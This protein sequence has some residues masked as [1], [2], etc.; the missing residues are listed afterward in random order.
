M[1]KFVIKPFTVDAIRVVDAIYLAAKDWKSLPPWLSEPYEKG[2]VVFATKSV[3]L[4]SPET[5]KTEAKIDD[6]IVKGVK[7]NLYG[8]TPELFDETYQEVGE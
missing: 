8:C 5:G 6:W 1:P 3:L 2:Q 7:G 4:Y